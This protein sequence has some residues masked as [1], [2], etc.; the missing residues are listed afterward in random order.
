MREVP[1]GNIDQQLSDAIEKTFNCFTEKEFELLD[2]LDNEIRSLKE[3]INEESGILKKVLLLSIPQS[4]ESVEMIIQ[5]LAEGLFTVEEL[6]DDNSLLRYVAVL[7]S[8][9]ALMMFNH[10]DTFTTDEL[11]ERR[12]EIIKSR[13]IEKIGA[14]PK[15]FSEGSYRKKFDEFVKQYIDLYGKPV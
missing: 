1:N 2:G 10:L 15:D 3:P 11:H 5:G 6:H 12:K 8:I 9:K 14:F 4:R 13:C 7:W